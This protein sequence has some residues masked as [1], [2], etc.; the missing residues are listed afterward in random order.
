MIHN[1]GWRPPSLQAR[2]EKVLTGLLP[3]QADRLTRR[4]KVGQHT[5]ARHVVHKLFAQ[6][7]HRHRGPA[8][9]HAIDQG[10]GRMFP[11]LEHIPVEQQP[12]AVVGVATHGRRIGPAC[13]I[14]RDQRQP[15]NLDH[16]LL[17]VTHPARQ[18]PN[19]TLE[20]RG[21]R[22]LQHA[23]QAGGRTRPGRA[24][25]GQPGPVRYDKVLQALLPLQ[26]DRLARC[27]KVGQHTRARY[28]VQQ[29]R[30]QRGHRHRSPVQLDAIDERH[31]R[32][33][34]V[35]EQVPVEQQ[36]K[37]VVGVPTH[38]CRVGPIRAIRRHQGRPLVHDDLDSLGITH[39]AG[40]DG[41]AT[42]EGSGGR[43][44]HHPGDKGHAQLVQHGH[45]P[46]PLDGHYNRPGLDGH[47]E[48]EVLPALAGR[49][50][51]EFHAVL[52]DGHAG[53]GLAGGLHKDEA[54]AGHGHLKVILVVGRADGTGQE[55]RQRQHG[56]LGG[57]PAVPV[58]RAWCAPAV[59]ATTAATTTAAI[60]TTTAAAATTTA[61]VAA[62]ATAVATVVVVVAVVV[63]V[64]VVV[65]VAVV[66]VVAVIAVVVVVVVVV[67]VAV[68][69]V[70]AVVATADTATTAVVEASDGARRMVDKFYSFP[71]VI[72]AGAVN[73]QAVS[74][75]YLS[76]VPADVNGCAHPV[77]DAQ[78]LVTLGVDSATLGVDCVVLPLLGVLPYVHVVVV[79]P[80][81][82]RCC[83]DAGDVGG[84]AGVVAVDGRDPVGVGLSGVI[85]GVGVGGRRVIFG[86]IFVVD[87]GPDDV[88]VVGGIVG[89]IF[90]LVPG[91]LGA[92]VARGGGPGQVDL[93]RVPG[94]RDG[95]REARRRPGRLGGGLRGRD[96]REGGEEQ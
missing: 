23:E 64:V 35:P 48:P 5:R 44:L 22:I 43:I 38:A 77:V 68:V 65:V 46:R 26:A 85:A 17:G 58:G 10:D 60:A 55:R 56:R 57:A 62:V 8:Q 71:L 39:P 63:V 2:N 54:R 19:A 20:G 13:A 59:D 93:P 70:I 82:V 14:R 53:R 12:K 95:G 91:D 34:P 1:S 74:H 61:A 40:D 80:A 94:L 31:D 3:G 28:V 87:A 33:L 75:Y 24:V 15:V 83:G 92:A 72:I 86:V 52:P 79:P 36:P 88:V 32:M 78:P 27:R 21:S 76:V 47:A 96:G 7:G 42:L 67:V 30:A 4:R 90:D 6:R 37:A 51:A 81:A 73:L 45:G 41:N 84:R 66:A 69:A 29:L 16:H 9:L 25:G 89:G 11:V 50:L 49:D 18:H